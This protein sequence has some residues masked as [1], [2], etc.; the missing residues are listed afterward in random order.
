MKNIFI[1][2]GTRPEAIKLAPLILQIRKNKTIS[3]NLK[4]YVCVTAQHRKMLDQVLDLFEITPDFDL[5]IMK[6]NQGLAD[7]TSKILLGLTELFSQINPS[8]V[9]VHG[10]T[11]TAFSSTLAAYYQKIPVAHIEAG[12]R[13]NDIFSPWPEEINR[14]FVSLIANIHFAP[15]SDAKNNLIAE[16]VVK[17]KILVTGNT[18]IDSLVNISN[19][20]DNDNNLKALLNNK[21]SFINSEKRMIL[22]TGHRREN[23]G[24]GFENICLAL[25]ELS[26]RKDVQIIYPVHLNPN[27]LIPVQKHLSSIENIFL[28]EPLEYLEFVYLMKL[29]FVILTDSGGIQEEAP[30][31]G[32][33]VLVL[34]NTTER[35]EAIKSGAARLVG[36]DK[37]KIVS[38]ATRL[39]EDSSEYLKMSNVTSP[40]GDGFA[41]KKILERICLF[42]NI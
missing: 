14:R 27:V 19:K 41:S 18:I 9:I 4:L 31:F 40:F 10:D 20:I 12:L 21:F 16:G 37:T 11:A 42:L 33:P 23:F 15:T 25:K 30:S 36:T 24:S 13:T 2:F 17:N 35:P 39:L 22:V 3:D 38:E 5:N 1:V 34:R 6:N 26:Y 32:K 28:I 29:S 8:L 7:V